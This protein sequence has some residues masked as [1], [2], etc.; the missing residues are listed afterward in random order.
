MTQISVVMLEDLQG[1]YS[2]MSLDLLILIIFV[3][4]V[5]VL[6]S[7]NVLSVSTDL[8]QSPLERSQRRG[9]HI[10]RKWDVSSLEILPTWLKDKA[11]TIAYLN[12][13]AKVIEHHYRKVIL[14]Q[15][16]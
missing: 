1:R 2:S 5:L 4:L 15:L 16:R 14:S 6:S 11:F 12:N 3:A 8:I 10:S 13:G 7:R 9:L